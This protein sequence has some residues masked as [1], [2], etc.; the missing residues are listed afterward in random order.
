MA[1]ARATTDDARASFRIAT[2]DGTGLADRA[3]DAV[4][5][6]LV[7]NNIPDVA[8]ALAEARRVTAPGGVIAGYVWDYADGME[9][10]RSF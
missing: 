8:A 10:I 3:V 6:G 1:H 9:L 2:A 4:V 5:Y 7:L